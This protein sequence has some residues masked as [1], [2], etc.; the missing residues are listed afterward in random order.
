MSAAVREAYKCPV[1]WRDVPETY[2]RAATFCRH[3]DK[4]GANC[5]MSGQPIPGVGPEV[6]AP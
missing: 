3:T 2:W 4:V 5:P 1:C 6:L